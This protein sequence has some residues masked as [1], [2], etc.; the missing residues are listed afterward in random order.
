MPRLHARKG[1]TLIELLVVIA[2][3]AVLIALLL[4]AVQQAREAARRTQCK[5][6]LKQ[7]G[8]ALHNYH[9]THLVFPFGFDEREALWSAQILPQIE[10]GNLFDTLIWQESGPGNWDSG[11]ANETA[12]ATLVPAY[13]CPSMA[14]PEHKDN[15]NIEGRVVTSYRVNA[16]SDIYCDDVTTMPSGA[17]AGARAFEQ[18]PQNGVFFGCSSVRLGD[19]SDGTSNTVMLGESYTTF[20]GRDGQDFDY[21]HVGSPQTG[22]WDLWEGEA[23]AVG[24]S[25]AGGTE[26]SE[27]LGS[28]GPK[29]NAWKDLTIHGSIAEAG[30]GS[31]HIGGAHIGLG[32]GS[33][34][35]VSDSVNLVVWHGLGT[36]NGGEVVSEF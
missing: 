21:W 25:G 36:R 31:Y 27:G 8:L 35:F 32:D 10:Q 19:L 13:R 1:F 11:S 26:F 28:T 34:R 30:F 15:N 23:A 9:D 4:P 2:I 18:V 22:G 12:C 3:I 20:D 5:N 17:P 6:N 7:L 24:G 16:G 33:V 14:Q 29:L